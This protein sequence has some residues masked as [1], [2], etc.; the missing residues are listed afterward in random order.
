MSTEPIGPQ[1]PSVQRHDADG[2]ALCTANRTNGEPCN[3]KAM[4]GQK[5]C[6]AHGGST[7][8][9]KRAAQRR[10]NDL[11]DPAI[12]TLDDTMANAD[13]ERVRLS[14]ADSVLDRTGWGR[15]QKVE[16]S[17][18]HNQLIER[19]LELRDQQDPDDESD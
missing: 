17:D 8:H 3:G 9:A 4:R 2:R 16:T 1:N 19:L 13:S 12:N 10:L 15:Q 14:A 7:K 5:V 18:A 6:Q 11:V